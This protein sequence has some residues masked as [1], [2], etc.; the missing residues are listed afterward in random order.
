VLVL[1]PSRPFPMASRI[2]RTAGPAS[3]M[4]RIRMAQFYP[5]RPL[6][7][8]KLQPGDAVRVGCGWSW[9]AQLWPPTPCLG[10]PLPAANES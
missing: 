8:E 7:A 6:P 3:D 5:R 4:T 10:Q 1:R 2:L 9:S